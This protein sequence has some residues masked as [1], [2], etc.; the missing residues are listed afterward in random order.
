M[1]ILAIGATGFLGPPTVRRLLDRGH[2]ITILNRSNASIPAG[3]SAIHGDRNRLAELRSEVARLSPE[4]VIDFILS[5]AGQARE[6]LHTV[7]GIAG[8]VLAISSMDVYRACAVL[9]RLDDGPLESVPLRE[10]AALRTQ[11]AYPKEAMRQLMHLYGWVTEDYDKVPV[12]Q[13]V[14]GDSE[15]PGTVLRLPMVYGEGDPLHRLWPILKRVQDGRAVIVLEEKLASWRAA[16]GY[17][18]NVAA[19]IALAAESRQSEGRVYNVAEEP[20][21]SELE[22]TRRV[23]AAAGWDGRIAVLPAERAPAHLRVLYNLDQHWV[24]DTSLFRRE[25][26]YHEPVE[27]ADALRLTVEWELANAPT[28]VDERMFDYA[29]EDQAIAAD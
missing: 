1:R 10:N 27:L 12:E 21:Y 28:R 15:I 20:A 8:R 22:W 3:A 26:G 9:H 16:R 13:V 19:A 18:G 17:V 5:D 29:A 24:A 2:E 25:L 23:A 6:L 7:R 14:L 11:P 4:L